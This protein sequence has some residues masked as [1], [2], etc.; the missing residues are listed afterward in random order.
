MSD[1]PLQLP[2]AQE[3]AVSAWHLY[4][5]RLHEGLEA[6]HREIFQGLRDAGIGVNLHYIPIHLQPYYRDLGFKDGDFPE[7]ERYYRQAISLPL[8]PDLTEAQQD[9]VVETLRRVLA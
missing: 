9:Q 5:V 7:A 8:F 2:A 4:V 3:Q 6:R 1:L